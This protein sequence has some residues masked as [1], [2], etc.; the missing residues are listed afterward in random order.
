MVIVNLIGRSEWEGHERKTFKDG[1]IVMRSHSPGK[2]W[3]SAEVQSYA[4]LNCL[5]VYKVDEVSP[6]DITRTV[7]SPLFAKSPTEIYRFDFMPDLGMKEVREGMFTFSDA[8]RSK[9][10]TEADK[11]LVG[12]FRI[13]MEN[14]TSEKD[15]VRPDPNTAGGIWDTVPGRRDVLLHGS[16]DELE[17]MV[18]LAVEGDKTAISKVSIGPVPIRNY[19]LDPDRFGFGFAGSKRYMFH[20]AEG[21][22]KA[23]AK[24][25]A[26]KLY[27]I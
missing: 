1:Y 3:K 4:W 2:F 9:P 12:D 16:D 5:F 7:P 11:E 20:P 24:K 23:F 21:D 14:L 15:S 25:V 13:Y 19:E 6:L 26:E 22:A 18:L 8:F 17:D 10:K 27:R